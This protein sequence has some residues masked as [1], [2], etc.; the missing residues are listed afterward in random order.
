MNTD[1]TVVS[2]RVLP[3]ICALTGAEN[4]S[5]RRDVVLGEAPPPW[6]IFML[7]VPM[8]VWFAMVFQTLGSKRV[9]LGYYLT[10]E[11]SKIIKGR[12]RKAMCMGAPGLVGF[13]VGIGLMQ[14][15]PLPAALLMLGGSFLIGTASWYEDRNGEPFRAVKV[16]ETSAVLRGLPPALV[17]LLQQESAHRSADGKP[18]KPGY[19]PPPAIGPA[20]AAARGAVPVKPVF[21]PLA[22][23]PAPPSAS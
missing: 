1:V 17:A 7:F 23:K 21:K 13:I 3:P 10:P 2:G 12:K 19:T 6:L 14:A 22:P 11:A 18:M 16:R 5:V 20:A 8:G 4:A 9:K 15:S